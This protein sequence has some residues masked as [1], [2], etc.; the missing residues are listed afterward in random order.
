MAVADRHCIA[1]GSGDCGVCTVRECYALGVHL[2]ANP[3]GFPVSVL[4]VRHR[5]LPWIRD[6]LRTKCAGGVRRDVYGG[7]Q[8]PHV[9][10]LREAGREVPGSEEPQVRGVQNLRA[11]LRGKI[12]E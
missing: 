2:G 11:A 1:S 12:R 4:K 9:R 5:E 8:L 10:V 6:H 3:G 7:G